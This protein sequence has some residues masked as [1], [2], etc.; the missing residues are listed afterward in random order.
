[1]MILL[2]AHGSRVPRERCCPSVAEDLLYLPDCEYITVD[3]DVREH[4][5]VL[6]DLQKDMFPWAEHS[7][8]YIIDLGGLAGEHIYYKSANFW[9]EIARTLKPSGTFYGRLSPTIVRY[10]TYFSVPSS[11]RIESRSPF[12]CRPSGQAAAYK[13]VRVYSERHPFSVRRREILSHDSELLVS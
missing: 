4:P 11:L 6:L 1:M 10:P 5:D 3:R 12:V 2:L 9:N 7:F 13:L 8:D